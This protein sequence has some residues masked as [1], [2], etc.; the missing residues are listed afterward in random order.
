MCE[1]VCSCRKIM[2]PF[3]LAS[4]LNPLPPNS[5]SCVFAIFE[6]RGNLSASVSGLTKKKKGDLFFLHERLKKKGGRRLGQ[7]HYTLK[8]MDFLITLITISS[9]SFSFITG[10][11]HCQQ[12]LLTLLICFSYIRIQ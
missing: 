1:V 3:S 11:I 4:S 6:K 9:D 2:L 10:Y 7:Q 12:K 8:I 5:L